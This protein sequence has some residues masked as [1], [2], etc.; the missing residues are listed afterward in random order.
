[1]RLVKVKTNLGSEILINIDRIDYI[2]PALSAVNFSNNYVMLNDESMKKVM[3]LI[4]LEGL[5]KR[6]SE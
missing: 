4:E 5:R 3:C 6:V 2:N 1:M